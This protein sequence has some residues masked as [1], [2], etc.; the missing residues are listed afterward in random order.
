M[1]DYGADNRGIGYSFSGIRVYPFPE[2][3]SRRRDPTIRLSNYK[4]G[5]L[6]RRVKRAGRAALSGA[7]VKNTLRYNLLPR[8]SSWHGAQLSIRENLPVY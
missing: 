2:R 3:S 7:E 1:S 6:P 4:R 5:S 8:T